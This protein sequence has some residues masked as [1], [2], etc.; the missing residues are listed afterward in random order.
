MLKAQALDA[1]VEG[2]CKRYNRPSTAAE[3]E[4]LLKV[5]DAAHPRA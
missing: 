5:Y 2:Y 1:F 4:R 3:T